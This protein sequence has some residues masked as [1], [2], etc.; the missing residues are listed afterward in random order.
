M[1]T[2][3]QLESIEELLQ[4]SFYEIPRFQRPYE[5]DSENLQQFWTDVVDDNDVGYFVG[6]MVAYPSGGQRKALVDG[7]QRMTTIM[8]ALCVVRDRL[9][10]LGETDFATGTNGFVVRRDRDNKERLILEAPDGGEI[11]NRILTSQ[12]FLPNI[13]AEHEGQLA[14]ERAYKQFVA[15][16]DQAIEEA[17]KDSDQTATDVILDVRNRLLALQVIWVERGDEDSAYI[18]FE[19]LNSRGKDLEPVDLLKNLLF[20][21]TKASNANLDDMR[22]RWNDMRELLHGRRAN[23]SNFLH[24]WWLSEHAFVSEKKLYKAMKEHYAKSLDAQLSDEVVADLDNAAKEYVKIAQPSLGDWEQDRKDLGRALVSL[25]E[26][27]VRQPRPLLLSI[28]RAHAEHRLNLKQ[29]KSMLGMIEAFHFASTAVVGVSSTGGI[30]QMY[31]RVAR[32]VAK[33]KTPND[34]QANV[35]NLRQSLS[36]SNRLPSRDAFEAQF[37]LLDYN[38][39][40]TAVRY[41]LRR[42]HLVNGRAYLDDD[43][44]SIEHFESQSTQELWVHGIGNLFWISKDLNNLLGNRSVLEKVKI[45]NANPQKAASY[46]IAEPLHE[47][48]WTENEAAVRAEEMASGLFDWVRNVLEL[49]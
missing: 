46:C 47:S 5:W 26:F 8:V 14:V 36:Q 44:S 20:S 21:K 33:A 40:K 32:N 7:Q 42:W 23:V 12:R 34:Q 29:A 4:G 31:A 35:V 18:I 27:G 45:L 10:D 6:P 11:L 41:S 19:T 1:D 30:S 48:N 25:R 39:Q 15:L 9:E 17:L 38:S 43:Y 24:H 28:L 22:N 49:P 37:K 13:K 2:K 16:L 3:I